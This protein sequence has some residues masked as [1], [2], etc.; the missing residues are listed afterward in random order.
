MTDLP[1]LYSKLEFDKVLKRIRAHTQSDLGACRADEI[2]P[3]ADLPILERELSLV[4]ECRSILEAEDFVGMAGV[5]DVRN[6]IHKASIEDSFISAAEFKD[7]LSTLMATRVLK[8]FL[9]KLKPKYALLAALVD[10][11]YVDR[12]LEYNI[13]QAIDENG[14][15][16]DS[17]SKHLR[18]IRRSIISKTDALREKLEKIVKAV[19]SEGCAQEE[20]LTTR[21]GR[22]VIP[23]K[24]EHKNHVPGFIHSS[25]SSGATVFIEPAETL[26]MNN[27]IRSLHF[28]EEREIERILR[29][30][31][32]QVRRVNSEIL[33]NLDTLGYI[34]LLFAKAKY[35]IEIV[36]SRPIVADRGPLNLDRA[37]HPILLQKH[38]RSE[39]VPLTL[40]L[41]KDYSTLLITGPNAGG[42]TVSLKTVGLLA[43]MAVCG[44]HVP[45]QPG[46][47]IPFFQDIFIDIGDEQSVENDLSSFSSHLL[48]V[49]SILERAN[50][51]SL[52]LLD[53]VGAGTD[54]IEGGALAAAFLSKLSENKTLT[55]ATTHHGT[56]K[57][58]AHVTPGF[59]NGA[60][61]FDQST[62]RP[63]YRFH[64]GVPGSSYAM[65]IAS[66]L[67]LP[68]SVL[69][70]AREQLGESRDRVEKLLADVQKKSQT[71]DQ[72][73]ATLTE[74]RERLSK[75]V[76]E[77][78]AK[79][80][81]ADREAKFIRSAALDQAQAKLN[82]IN[83]LIESSIKE[84]KERNAERQALRQVK[85]EI[86]RVRS[87]IGEELGALQSGIQGKS[88]P[89]QHKVGDFVRLKESNEVGEVVSV[90][91]DGERFTVQFAS[92]RLQLKEADL[93]PAQG[94]EPRRPPT[95]YWPERKEFRSEIDVR[96]MS[97]VEAIEAV[98]KFLDDASVAAYLTVSIIHGKGTG[99]LRKRI[100]DYL[101]KS[102]RVDSYRMGDW[103]EGGAGVTV[104]NLKPE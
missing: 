11:L 3:F 30:L 25:S 81:D 14:A 85:S 29:I 64:R 55:I 17:A 44:L 4:S 63:T 96:G 87:E 102:A 21:D 75:L 34:D 103:N 41:G 50:D 36:A 90:G 49:K 104:V 80:K 94:L 48:N 65:E 53:E 100:S 15:V 6:I 57:A 88:V 42:K 16:R 28:S 98:D 52:V 99:A 22:M 79:V 27:E 101:G 68:L 76:I 32:S 54:P 89:Q 60:M 45:A 56:L 72:E 9:K 8:D 43:L 12:V 26:E 73:I 38:P 67:G 7:V 95:P 61:E 24:A 66:R 71:L 31:T 97:T 51:Q 46:S 37:Y 35:S 18:D 62:L 47:Q 5:K 91:A 1:R 74:Q 40:E 70:I 84:I 93:L 83:S 33:N 59:E 39:V 69:S 86:A 78:Q 23:V 82:Q 13:N 58:F 20:I 19:S 10:A 92:F 2:V 77:Y